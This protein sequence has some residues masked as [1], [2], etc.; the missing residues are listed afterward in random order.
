MCQE[1][2]VLFVLAAEVWVNLNQN[3][4]KKSDLIVFGAFIFLFIIHIIS[5]L[6][7][8]KADKCPWSE[9]KREG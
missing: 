7:R 2:G 9:S 8:Y 1:K 4:K 3:K 6:K 5:D